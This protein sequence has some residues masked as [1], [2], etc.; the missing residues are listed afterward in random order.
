MSSDRRAAISDQPKKESNDDGVQDV[1]EERADRRHDDECHVC[2]A[3]WRWV[4]AV[5]FA[6]AVG[7]APRP[8][9][10]SPAQMTAAS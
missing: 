4:T 8:N 10:I 6:I 1:D 3:P 2:D 7:V 9:P 5:M